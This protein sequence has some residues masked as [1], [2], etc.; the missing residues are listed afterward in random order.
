MFPDE[1]AKAGS[2]SGQPSFD[3]A[4]ANCE[5]E[6]A[7]RKSDNLEVV[8]SLCWSSEDVFCE[9]VK[10][11]AKQNNRLGGPQGHLF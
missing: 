11:R 4:S 6:V 8:R 2:W 10:I 7:R 1:A 5:I 9:V 3:F